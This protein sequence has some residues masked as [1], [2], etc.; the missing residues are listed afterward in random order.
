MA[1]DIE[2]MKVHYTYP[3]IVHKLWTALLLNHKDCAES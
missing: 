3:A 1:D 2:A